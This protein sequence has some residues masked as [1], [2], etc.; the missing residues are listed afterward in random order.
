MTEA[1]TLTSNTSTGFALAGWLA[2]VSAVLFTH[3]RQG[4]A[5]AVVADSGRA[6]RSAWQV[7]AISSSIAW[8]VK[9][10]R[11][12]CRSYRK[13]WCGRS[14]RGSGRGARVKVSLLATGLQGGLL[15]HTRKPPS[16]G[17]T[18]HG[19]SAAAR[20]TMGLHKPLARSEE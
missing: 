7:A 1:E 19:Q 13:E 4:A 17:R 8:N 9:L 20:G 2:I 15:L 10:S 16:R 6:A 18:D 5:S 11:D 12:F 3:R 14:P